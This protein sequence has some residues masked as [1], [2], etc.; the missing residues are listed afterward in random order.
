[1]ESLAEFMGSLNK[2]IWG[3]PLIILLVGTHLFLTFYLR[4]IQKHTILGI[5]L[6][7]SKKENEAKGDVSPFAALAT[8]LAA[9]IGTGNIVG[10]S[11]AV[12]LGGPG[13]VFWTWIAGVLGMATKYSEALLSVKYRTRDA[14]GNFVGG[15]MYAIERGMGPK[16]KPLAAA[17]AVLTVLASFGIGSLVQSNSMSKFVSGAFN[18]PPYITG[19]V[20][21]ILA[22]TVIM[23]GIKKISSICEKLVPFMAAF[24]IISCIT[25]LVINRN[26][27]LEALSLIL[28]SAF[29]ARAA[30]GGFIASTFMSACRAGVARGIFSNES[31]LGTAA[32]AAAT[33][34]SK[35]PVHQALV[36]M[37]G[38][39]W[40]TVVICAMTGLVVVTSILH[41]PTAYI[42]AEETDL[43]KNSFSLIPYGN[44]VLTF[45]L[46]I[47][48]FTTI[49]G[50]SFYG[51]RAIGYLFGLKSIMVY[52]I[53][54]LAA[55]LLGA[56]TSIAL[57]WDFADIANGLMA[58]P[59]L[60]AILVLSSV[61][62][63]ETKK[64]L[65]NNNM[66]AVAQDEKD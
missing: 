48:A 15:P 35:N 4:A 47:F 63:K 58:V 14:E 36:S 38:T 20:I 25:I 2:W 55:I 18:I 6:S 16:W 3:Y 62:F 37:T 49:I 53:V 24:Y 44:Y 27:I 29:T 5:K 45:A 54:F 39:F 60:I 51:E 57:V 32:I 41:N 56:I 64:Y 43:V 46:C 66:D 23:G 33:A 65:W 31:G 40:D 42:G 1:M 8:A 9:T 28:K 11:T 19:L 10:V 22:A 59:N 17:F 34:Q 26:F 13:A 61:I 50:W 30:T 7:F 52:R 12:F 21:M